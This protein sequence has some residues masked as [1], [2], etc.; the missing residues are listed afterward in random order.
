[1]L[2]ALYKS[3]GNTD[4]WRLFVRQPADK[5][6]R[7]RWSDC[8]PTPLA[9]GHY[10]P[11]GLTWHNGEII[12]AVSSENLPSRVF[13]ISSE[14]LADSGSFEMPKDATHTS[15]LAWDGE[16]LWAV[17]HRARRCYKM[18]L[19]SSFSVGIAQIVGAFDTGLDGTSACC[20]LMYRGARVL[21]ISQFRKGRETVFVN[22]QDAILDESVEGHQVFAYRNEGFS[23][24]LEFDGNY[25]Y[26]SEN[27]AGTG[28]INKIDLSLLMNTK[29]SFLSTI[30]QYDAPGW[31]VEDLAWDGHEMWTTDEHNFRLFKALIY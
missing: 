4:L 12:M 28:V 26:E 9:G 5:R 27:K 6:R 19:A 15:G 7:L 2:L 21:A 20:F 25:L 29:D 14:M 30:A 8:G 3:R 24:G 10:T 13:R 16:Y 23:Q 1:M 31:G 22:H 17:D 11:Q 18:D